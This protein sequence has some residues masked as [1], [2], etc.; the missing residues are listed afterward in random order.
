MK[1]SEINF[2]EKNNF[3]FNTGSW[4]PRSHYK[5]V[6]STGRLLPCSKAQARF[7]VQNNIALD[8]LNNKDVENIEALLHKHGFVGDYTYT[9]SKRWV[10]LINQND[11]H[12][13]LKNEYL[14]S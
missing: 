13:A 1:A 2:K 5:N 3:L 11:L 14:K 7:F 9:K 6:M 4:A 10:R 12:L 8:V